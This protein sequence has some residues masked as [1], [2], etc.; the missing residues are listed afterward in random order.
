[1]ARLLR[2][3]SKPPGVTTGISAADRARTVQAAVASNARPED[4]VQQDI[5]F[6]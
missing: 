3:P 6:P 4:I 2:Y 1:M 5:F